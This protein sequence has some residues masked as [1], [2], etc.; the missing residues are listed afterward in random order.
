MAAELLCRYA[1]WVEFWTRQGLAP[2][3]TGDCK[4]LA[5][6]LVSGQ[7]DGDGLIAKG[8][9]FMCVWHAEAARNPAVPGLFIFPHTPLTGVHP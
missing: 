1:R 8:T 6:H 3:D 7:H 4:G 5:T 2:L 9:T